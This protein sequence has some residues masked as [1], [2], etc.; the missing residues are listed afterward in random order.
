MS[1]RHFT[2]AVRVGVVRV[3]PMFMLVFHWL[4]SVQMLMLF[5]QVQPDA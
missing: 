5:A 2:C 3:V 4:V 1:R